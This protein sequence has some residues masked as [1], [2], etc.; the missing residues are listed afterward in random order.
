M[1]DPAKA[2]KPACAEDNLLPAVTGG[3]REEDT[4]IAFGV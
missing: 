2:T 3:A 1:M 4:E